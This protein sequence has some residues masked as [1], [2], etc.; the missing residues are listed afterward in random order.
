MLGQRNPTVLILPFQLSELDVVDEARALQH[1][2]EHDPQRALERHAGVAI[3]LEVALD[4][5]IG[6]GPPKRA[7]QQCGDELG[8]AAL[9]LG[10]RR[11]PTR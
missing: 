9:L 2:L 7:R 11:G 6:D 5:G 10:R 1:R 4:V 3:E 8:R